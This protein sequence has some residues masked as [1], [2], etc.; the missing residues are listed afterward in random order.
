MDKEYLPSRRE[1]Y[2][3]LMLELSAED[4]DIEMLRKFQSKLRNI[5]QNKYR[6]FE[7]EQSQERF[8]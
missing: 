2:Y 4:G 5:R 3:K 1:N 8:V 7:T 6:N